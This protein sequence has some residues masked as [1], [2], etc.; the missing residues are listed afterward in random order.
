MYRSCQHTMAP[1]P[2]NP[3]RDNKT[4]IAC[5]CLCISLRV[6]VAQ[7]LKLRGST[8]KAYCCVHRNTEMGCRV[9]SPQRRDTDTTPSA[10]LPLPLDPVPYSLSTGH[11]NIKTQGLA[12]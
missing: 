1:H 10:C 6:C 5:M 2:Q 11:Q 4:H 12:A 3:Q 7:M 9:R 8:P